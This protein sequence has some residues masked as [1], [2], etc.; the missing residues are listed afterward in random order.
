MGAWRSCIW[1]SDVEGREAK[2]GARKFGFRRILMLERKRKEARQVKS[3]S[4]TVR[5]AERSLQ[6]GVDREPLTP[7]SAHWSPDSLGGRAA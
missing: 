7:S 1:L 2:A 5:R 6:T 4:K 3:Q